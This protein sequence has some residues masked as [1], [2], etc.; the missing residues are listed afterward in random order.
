MNFH[1]YSHYALSI[2][3]E[4]L[5]R[6]DSFMKVLNITQNLSYCSDECDSCFCNMLFTTMLNV[7]L[8]NLFSLLQKICLAYH[9]TLTLTCTC[10]EYNS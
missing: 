3:D 7:Y 6:N 9:K 10:S 4:L 8:F 2:D 1:H 5:H